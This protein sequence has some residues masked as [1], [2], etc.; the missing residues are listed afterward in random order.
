MSRDISRCGIPPQKRFKKLSRNFAKN[1][2][3][4]KSLSMNQFCRIALLIFLIKVSAVAYAGAPIASVN[5]DNDEEMAPAV[6]EKVTDLE[7]KD[8]QAFCNNWYGTRYQYGGCSRSGID[9]SCFART[10]YKAVYGIELERSSAVQYKQTK[11]VKRIRQLE[12][13]DLVFF[14]VHSMKINHVGVYIGDRKF[15][16]ATT[17]NGVIVSSLDEPNYKREFYRAGTILR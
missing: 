7:N 10:L 3:S 9:C 13:G 1:N 14:R 15:I 16:H 11:R 5:D 17:A 2:Y 4:R 12:E 6:K 8:L